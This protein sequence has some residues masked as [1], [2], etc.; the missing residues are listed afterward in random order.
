[1]SSKKNY[2]SMGSANLPSELLSVMNSIGSKNSNDKMAMLRLQQQDKQFQLNQQRQNRLDQLA[3]TAVTRE[4]T[5]YQQRRDDLENAKLSTLT[6]LQVGSELEINAPM[7][8][9]RTREINYTGQVYS[10]KDIVEIEKTYA[11]GKYDLS[12]IKKNTDADLEFEKNYNALK[13]E[14][15]DPNRLKIAQLDLA[16]KYGIKQEDPNVVIP[17]AYGASKLFQGMASAGSVIADLGRTDREIAEA[18]INREEFGKNLDK[19]FIGNTQDEAIKEKLSSI[20]NIRNDRV[21]K[22]SKIQADEQKWLNS[23][24]ET[25]KL[26]RNVTDKDVTLAPDKFRTGLNSDKQAG[27]NKIMS[28]VKLDTT[29]KINAIEVFNKR[30]AEKNAIY[31]AKRAVLVKKK[32]EYDKDEREIKTFTRKEK[33]KRT[34]TEL[35]QDRASLLKRQEKQ[36]LTLLQKGQLKKIN[37]EL[38]LD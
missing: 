9:D 26:T 1:M 35:K 33:V 32:A 18:N 29:G 23:L 15:K 4:E 22:E 34:T 20:D 10:P 25:K 31:E 12:G 37:K 14:Y 6:G 8:G 36:E 19:T 5:R 38:G 17:G 30:L 7:T 21:R 3:A 13:D 28:D 27:Y 24:L 11:D 16:D 2:V